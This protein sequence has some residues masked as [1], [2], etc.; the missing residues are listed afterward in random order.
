MFDLKPNAPPEIR[1]EFKPIATNV[2]GIQIGECFPRI[3]A[4]MDKYVAIR[5]VIGATGGHDA[6]QCTTGYPPA[7]LSPLGGR[8]SMGSAVAKVQGTVDPSVPAFVG[9]AA[10]TQHR[11]WSDA[12][13]TGFLGPA[14]GPFR[15]DGPGMANLKLNGISVEH[16]A[17]RRRLLSS[18]DN[19]RRE[20]DSSEALR[21]MDAATERAFGVLTSSRLLE[22]M[23]ISRE[24]A[25]VRERA[26]FVSRTGALG[27]EVLDAVEERRQSLEPV[28]VLLEGA[29]AGAEPAVLG[30]HHRR[31]LV[32]AELLE[33]GGVAHSVSLRSWFSPKW[34]VNMFLVIL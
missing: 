15:P 3:A 26:R 11:P 16:M 31:P 9:L 20:V 10:P 7:S 8:P 34:Y 23:D 21:G 14:Y 30:P 5:S 32:L 17:D 33:A 13:R 2:T 25:K 22:A 4:S 27:V 1:G 28:D 6:F 29:D 12:G 24:P 18:F 19:M